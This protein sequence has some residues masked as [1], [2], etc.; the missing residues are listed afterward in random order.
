MIRVRKGLKVII[1]ILLIMVV[2]LLLLW[3]AVGNEGMKL[4]IGGVQKVLDGPPDYT[5]YTV[6]LSEDVKN[7]LCSK[8]SISNSD[9]LCQPGSKV[10]A[11]DF[12]TVIY[13]YFDQLPE[14][15]K[16]LDTVQER[17]GKYQ[18]KMEEETQKES[19]YFYYWYDFTGDQKFPLVI[20]F[21]EDGRIRR[22]YLSAGR[23]SG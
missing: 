23:D 18:F 19:R 6:P 10:Y 22:F 21:E 7:D 8:F 5:K 4:I 14:N 15:L 20:G 2:G 13:H 12:Y 16:R 17:I 1:K 11:F 3:A 9:R